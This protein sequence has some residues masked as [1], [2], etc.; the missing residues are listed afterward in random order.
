MEHEKYRKQSCYGSEYPPEM[1]EHKGDSLMNANIAYPSL[2][3][4]I[5]EQIESGVSLEELNE[6][7]SGVKYSHAV[8]RSARYH[9]EKKKKAA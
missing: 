6:F 1:L 7:I 2:P 4:K 9:F 5:R 3:K 8:K